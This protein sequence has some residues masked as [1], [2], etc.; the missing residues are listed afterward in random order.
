[1]NQFPLSIVSPTAR[2]FASPVW[3]VSV[4][5][6]EGA[7]AVRAHHCNMVLSLVPG[8]IEVAVTPDD[9]REFVIRKGVLR[10]SANACVIMCEGAEPGSPS[11]TRPDTAGK[12]R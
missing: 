2:H 11:A 7:L 5:N 6:R 10:F 1:M 9:R 12:P 4:A 3:Q 8:T